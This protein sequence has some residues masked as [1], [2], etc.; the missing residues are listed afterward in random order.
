[1][2]VLAKIHADFVGCDPIQPGPERNPFPSEL[3][4]VAKGRV[5]GIGCEIFRQGAIPGPA[6]DKLEI[7]G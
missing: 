4:D 6:I 7:S 3:V 5:E 1:M 2:A